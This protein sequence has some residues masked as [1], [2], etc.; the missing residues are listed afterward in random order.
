MCNAT[1]S[2]RRGGGGGQGRGEA[3][4]RRDGRHH[5]YRYNM[6]MY[7]IIHIYQDAGAEEAAKEGRKLPRAVTD[8]IADVVTRT[9]NSVRPRYES[10]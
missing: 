4:A 10:S 3:A 6:I 1:I 7:N 5:I 8:D 2:G 9:V